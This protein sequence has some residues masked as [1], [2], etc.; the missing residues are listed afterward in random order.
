MGEGIEMPH[1]SAVVPS[2]AG[3]FRVPTAGGI[4]PVL[5]WNGN[6]G[7]KNAAMKT[8]NRRT[9]Q[10]KS[11]MNRFEKRSVRLETDTLF[12]FQMKIED[13]IRQREFEEEQI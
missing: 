5:T 7:R 2:P 13:Y 8:K 1:T 9:N 12:Y 3:N 6:T 4:F 11:A 10:F